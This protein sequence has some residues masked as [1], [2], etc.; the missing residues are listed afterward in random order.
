MVKVIKLYGLHYKLLYP[1]AT[2]FSMNFE[3]NGFAVQK[4]S[5]KRV[6]DIRKMA[7]YENVLDEDL[8]F[9]MNYAQGYDT[10]LKRYIN[11]IS[12]LKKISNVCKSDLNC[13]I[14]SSREVTE[15]E[16]YL[17]NFNNKKH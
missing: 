1:Y 17:M 3:M 12:K 16:F 14:F 6:L 15:Q 5:Y 11:T 7:I 8:R 10:N 2:T 4:L 13:S 9:L